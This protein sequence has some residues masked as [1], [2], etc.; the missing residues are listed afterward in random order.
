MR[1]AW[2]IAAVALA[3]TALAQDEEGSF[4]DCAVCP[5]M[6]VVPS[7]TFTRGSSAAEERPAE[8]PQQR[9]KIDAPIAIGKYEVTFDEWGAC[10][11]DGGC[12]QVPDDRG[13]GR[14][15]R[16]VIYVSWDDAQQYV[17]W[18]SRKTGREYRLPSETEWEY[19]ARAGTQTRY[20]FGDH[21]TPRQVNYY[22][23]GTLPVG[24]FA[25]NGFGLHDMHGNVWEWTEDCWNP[26]YVGAPPN[27]DPRRSGDCSRHVVRGGS[28]DDYPW[29]VRSAERSTGATA[30]RLNDLGFRVVVT[31]RR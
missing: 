29:F 25:A 18:L 20:A 16:P 13:W 22:T 28:W 21:V 19:S 23:R 11:R 5:E 12:A 26:N 3:P 7:G 17:R 27:A 24:S 9:V 2:L 4:R 15:R 8:T 10:V 14:G 1:A 6:V 31:L 30:V